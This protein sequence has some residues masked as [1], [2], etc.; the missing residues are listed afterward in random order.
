MKAEEMNGKPLI[1]F[2][3]SCFVYIE[4]YKT[5]EQIIDWLRKVGYC[6]CPCA[7]FEGWNTLHC[8][9]IER[10]G[11]FYPEVHGVVDRDE[12]V[13]YDIEQF[14]YENSRKRHPHID[15]G[16][17]I[18]LFMALA[19]RNI[20]NDR[21]QW[22]TDGNDWI[23]CHEDTITKLTISSYSSYHKATVREIIEHFRD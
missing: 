11:F 20:N 15:C 8:S 22:F 7:S 1:R 17:N 21:E 16:S 18:V 14:K 19:A 4:D 12:Y 10:N 2:I 13:N 23:V 6:V 9:M 3:A 5:R